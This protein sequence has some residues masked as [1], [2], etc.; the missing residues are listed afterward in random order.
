MTAEE[1]HRAALGY[2]P[3]DD[4]SDFAFKN[5]TLTREQ[6][7]KMMDEPKRAKIRY[8]QGVQVFSHNQIETSNETN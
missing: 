3:T 6:Y 1:I 5:V 4:S 7:F 2:T 8:R